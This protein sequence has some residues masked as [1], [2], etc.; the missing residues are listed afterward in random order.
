MGKLPS[1]TL[2]HTPPLINTLI[3][4]LASVQLC[5]VD[6]GGCYC[7]CPEG[8]PLRAKRS[9]LLIAIAQCSPYQQH[10]GTLL[11][12]ALW[13]QPNCQASRLQYTV[14]NLQSNSREGQTP[15]T[16]ADMA[17]GR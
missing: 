9:V 10:T 15:A 5:V 7:S 6:R 16:A 14:R 2:A 13:K 4:A 17:A 11:Q 8:C 1:L 12:V 3:A